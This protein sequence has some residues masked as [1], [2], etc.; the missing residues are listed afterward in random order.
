MP[1]IASYPEAEREIFARLR[2][3]LSRLT[4][5][6]TTTLA[7]GSEKVATN[8]RRGDVPKTR[9]F[10]RILHGIPVPDMLAA[11]EPLI[12]PAD[13]HAHYAKLERI[14]AL[15]RETRHD[16]EAACRRASNDDW[17]GAGGVAP[18]AG[19]A[20]LSEGIR[21]LRALG[22]GGGGLGEGQGSPLASRPLA[23]I[24]APEPLRALLERWK[25]E[26]G[27]DMAALVSDAAQR[28]E[29]RIGIH[30]ERDGTLR[31]GY[32][33]PAFRLYQERDRAALIGRPL[34]DCPDRAYAA[35]CE[36][37]MVAMLDRREPR[38]DDV[39][40]IATPERGATLVLRYARLLLPYMDGGRRVVFSASVMRPA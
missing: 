24:A 2:A 37:D 36:R 40:A 16:R 12:G 17:G 3:F 1:R 33:S 15:I 21:L 9:T 34:T 26:G 28:P 5:K 35:A 10:L 11:L 30:S 22:A 7:G 8:A 29:T 19:V 27:A 39:A 25:A 23:L 18:P 4:L 6:E 38:L 20:P 32:I 13:P 31:Y 14:E